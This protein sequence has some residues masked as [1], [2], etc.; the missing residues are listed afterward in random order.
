MLI[1]RFAAGEDWKPAVDLTVYLVIRMKAKNDIWL[2]PFSTDRAG[3]IALS[4]DTLDHELQEAIDLPLMD[5]SPPTGGSVMISVV[6]RSRAGLEQMAQLLRSS[7]PVH[8]VRLRSALS[9]YDND[10]HVRRFSRPVKSNLGIRTFRI[11]L[12]AGGGEGGN[13]DA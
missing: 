6:V 8:S 13:D 2:G 9:H 11:H 3:R 5:Y 1:L 12:D 10:E 7:C 4:G